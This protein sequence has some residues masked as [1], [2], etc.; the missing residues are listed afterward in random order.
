MRKKIETGINKEGRNKAIG[1]RYGGKR[2]TVI[3]MER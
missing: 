3:G 1:G 2:E